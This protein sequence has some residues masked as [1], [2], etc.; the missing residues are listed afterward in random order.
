MPHAQRKPRGETG[1]YIVSDGTDKPLRM[2]IRT[3]SLRPGCFEEVTARLLFDRK[4]VIAVIG[5]FDIVLPEV[6][7]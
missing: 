6:D 3:G 1:Y 2:K 7:R 5:S 4:D